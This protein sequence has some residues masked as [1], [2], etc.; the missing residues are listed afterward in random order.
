MP[1]YSAKQIM[2]KECVLNKFAGSNIWIS[3]INSP[4]YKG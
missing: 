3:K 4:A 2:K 1:Q